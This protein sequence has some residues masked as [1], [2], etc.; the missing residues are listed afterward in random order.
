MSSRSVRR[1]AGFT[2]IEL[3]VVIAI[4]AILIA[5]LLPAVQQAREAARRTQCKNHLKQI[6]LALHNYLDTFS[7]WPGGHIA[8]PDNVHRKGGTLIH[9]LPFLELATV[10]NQISPAV[11]GTD[12]MADFATSYAFIMNPPAVWLCPTNDDGTQIS[13]WRTSGVWGKSGVAHYGPNVGAQRID[14]T[15]SCSQFI[16]ANGYFGAATANMG[17][18]LDGR[19]VSGPFSNRSWGA[20]I[21]DISDGTSN[22]IAFGE[23]RPH[24]SVYGGQGPWVCCGSGVVY[25]VPP[26]NYPTC[27]GEKGVPNSVSSGTPAGCNNPWSASTAEGIKSKHTGGAH[28]LLCDGA[29]RFLSENLDYDTLQRLGDRRDNNPVGEF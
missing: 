9:L 10:Y 12:G 25:T 23:Q 16:Y 14:S 26:I 11:N 28:V 21:R 15:N 18:S 24:C 6:G 19:Q 27:P 22:T 29:V 20:R 13:S 8:S 1:P 7:I 17:D 3:L 4:I 2:L 5:L